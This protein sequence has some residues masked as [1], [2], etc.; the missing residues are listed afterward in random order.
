MKDFTET[1]LETCSSEGATYADIRI[2]TVRGED[3]TFKDGNID[4]LSLT[5]VRGFGIRAIA[6]GGWGFAGS[7]EI[8]K[9][10]I[11]DTARLA[12]R[13]AKA[14]GST[15][16]D[17]VVLVNTEPVEDKYETKIKK[18]P[19]KVPVEE[20]LEILTDVDKRLGRFSDSIK[21]RRA[22][23]RAHREDK[24]FASTEAAQIVQTITWC[25]GGFSCLAVGTGVPPQ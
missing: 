4:V 1:A 19:F 20:K 24:V 3:I 6:D 23:Y 2:V 8:S 13:I 5:T 7:H 16:K 15:R 14:S 10:E 25:G 11:Q 12:V 18:D 21:V 9:D 22:D 17:P